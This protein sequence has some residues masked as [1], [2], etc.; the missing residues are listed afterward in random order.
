RDLLAEHG[1]PVV[2]ARLARSPE[3][4]AGAAGELGWPVVLKAA[5]AQVVH[6][7][8]VGG[9]RLDVATPAEAERAYAEI[10]EQVGA[11]RPD[12]EREALVGAICALARL[13]EG[14]GDALELLEINPLW[15]SGDRVEALDALALWR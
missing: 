1:V 4:A 11:A 7:S 13:A 8:D 14:L 15:V 10:V 6:K 2:P 3:E 5:S 9:V 12:A